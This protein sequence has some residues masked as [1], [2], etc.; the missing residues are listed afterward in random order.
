MYAIRDDVRKT[1]Q[2]SRDTRW[3]LFV[4]IVTAAVAI[5]GL[6]VGPA[7]YG[8]ALFWRGMNVREVIQSTVKDTIEHMGKMP[9][10]GVPK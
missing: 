6:I 3:V 10:I 7:T 9:P 8:D 1:D 4:T 5:G 2:Y